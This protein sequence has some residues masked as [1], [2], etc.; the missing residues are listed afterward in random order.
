MVRIGKINSGMFSNM[1]FSGATCEIC[2]K[3]FASDT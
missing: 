1:G 2:G 3:H